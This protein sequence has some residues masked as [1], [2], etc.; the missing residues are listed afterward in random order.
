MNLRKTKAPNPS[1]VNYLPA[2]NI[3]KD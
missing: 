2:L 1:K 3:S